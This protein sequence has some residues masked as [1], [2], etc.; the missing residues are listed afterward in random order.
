MADYDL[1]QADAFTSVL[2][3]GNPAAIMPLEEWLPDN[4][5]QAIAI[6]N[7]LAE[8]AYVI[9][10]GGGHYDL[11]WFTPGAEVDL[12]GHATLATAHILYT[13]RGETA[14]E[15]TFNTR[16][17]DLT[18]KRDGDYYVMNFPAYTDHVPAEQQIDL[19]EEALGARPKEVISGAF[20]LAVFEDPQIVRAM[21]P[22]Q[23][24]ISQLRQP[25][26]DGCVL[27]TAPGDQGYD[28]IS[29]FFAPAHGIPEDPVTGS[30]HCM[31]TPYWA[32]KLGKYD[33]R[34][35]QESPRGGEVLCTLKQDRVILKG[36]AVT[37]LRGRIS[38]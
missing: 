3:K 12:C 1:Y 28:F 21:K 20:L 23:L 36:K 18:I 37:Y 38:L 35:Y 19:V 13:E 33:F 9:A 5:L 10:R 32:E 34:A 7:N 24:K 2:F 4:I 14:E 27:V 26:H 16:S 25:G 22:D 11:R 31:T 30:A 8:T 17:G 15:I 6:E 29:R